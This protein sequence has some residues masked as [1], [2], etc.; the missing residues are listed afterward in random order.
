MIA[1]SSLGLTQ[2]DRA[3][4]AMILSLPDGPWDFAA[5]YKTAESYFADIRHADGQQPW[6]RPEKQKTKS[7]RQPP[8]GGE[9]IIK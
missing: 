2:A 4:V 9:C 8:R 7:R 6:N 3:A 1:S 5:G